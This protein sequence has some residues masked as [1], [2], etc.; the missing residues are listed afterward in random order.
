MMTLKKAITQLKI[1][2][3]LALKS[4]YIKKPLAWAFYQTWKVVDRMEEERQ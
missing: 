1:Y 4:E 2:Y 3:D